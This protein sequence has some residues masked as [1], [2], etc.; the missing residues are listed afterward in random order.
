MIVVAGPDE[1]PSITTE[2]ADTCSVRN[3]SSMRVI[4]TSTWVIYPSDYFVHT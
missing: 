3:I 1:L 4:D 2:P